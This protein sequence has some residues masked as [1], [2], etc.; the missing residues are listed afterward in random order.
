MT[1]LTLYAPNQLKIKPKEG[2]LIPFNFNRA[3]LY[4]HERC[5]EQKKRKGWVRLIILKG[6][7]QGCS[8][9]VGARFYHST[10]CTTDTLTFIFAHDSEGSSSLYDMV[11]RFYDNSSDS[12]FRPQL[13]NS[14]AKELLFPN[15]R[16]GYKVGTAGT[17]GLGRSKTMQQV[18]WSEVAYS[19]NCSDHAAGILQTVPLAPGTEII[20]ESTANG[21]GDYFHR[22]CKQALSGESDYELVF[23]PWYWQD[24]Y[25]RDV[26]E[27]FE[28]SPEEK[29][30]LD[31]FGNDGLTTEHLV[32]RRY[33][34]TSDFEGD[35]MRFKR[36]YPFT[37]EEAFEASDENALIKANNVRKARNTPAVQ[38]SAPLVMGID[39]A[40]LG[41]D[42]FRVTHRKGRNVTKCYRLPAMT[43]TDS[44][45]RVAQDIQKYKP[46]R[47]FIDAGGLG[48]GLYDM[49]VDMGYGDIVVKV[50]FGGKALDGDRYFN[51]RAE[52]YGE[53]K[54]WLEDEP[55]SINI[56]EREGDALQSELSSVHYQWRNNS[57]IQLEPKEKHKERLGNSPDMADS[58]VL[59]FAEPVAQTNF[60]GRMTETHVSQADWNPFE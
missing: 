58:F 1:D 14:N 17:K 40:R 45:K 43:L 56:D 8:T 50:D 21:Q 29:E 39:P 23:I 41:G 11:K 22:M 13:G 35:D 5:E 7:Q 51:K 33:K 24:E 53:A 37:P 25:K 44:A 60:V 47:V 20:L 49:L 52:M 15:I 36:E 46:A 31:L 28:L 12:S 59:T 48:V 38:T 26:P 57:Q 6:R 42:K 16:S 30:Y 4:L 34:I 19:P 54:D 9:Y 55:C 27:D 10:A 18:H 2:P 3:Q 32:W